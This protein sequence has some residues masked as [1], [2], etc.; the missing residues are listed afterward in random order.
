M[1]CYQK[2][3]NSLTTAKSDKMELCRHGYKL[4]TKEPKV[5]GATLCKLQPY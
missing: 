3:S 4:K 2:Q 5:L 1:Q